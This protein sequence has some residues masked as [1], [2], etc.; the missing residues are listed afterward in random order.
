MTGDQ[1]LPEPDRLIIARFEQGEIPV[2]EWNQRMHVCVA[3]IYLRAHGLEGAL[4]RMREGVKRINAV[5]GVEESE[6]SGYNETTTVAFL[7]IVEAIR[8]AYESIYPAATADEFCDLHPE[9]MHK[10]VLR[11][12]YSPERRGHRDAKTEFIEPDLAP[13]PDYRGG[14]GGIDAPR[15]SS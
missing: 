7:R 14:E 6:R 8:R 10:H 2:A 1:E 5:H 11:F 12:F 13:L 3:F 9:L 4:S 15:G